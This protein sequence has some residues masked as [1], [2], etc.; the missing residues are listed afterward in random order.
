M[1]QKLY[2]CYDDSNYYVSSNEKKLASDNLETIGG[3]LTFFITVGVI[4]VVFALAFGNGL[5][6]YNKY[7]PGFIVLLIVD[8]AL[9]YIKKHYTLTFKKTRIVSFIFYAIIILTFSYVD[10]LIYPE[11]RAVFFPCAIM[12]ICSL[13]MDY[14]FIMVAYKI[15][16][17][18][19]F[20]LMDISFKSRPVLINDITVC[21]LAI[22]ASSFCH[23]AVV[24]ATLSRKEDNIALIHKSET[25]LLTGLLNKLSFEERCKEYIDK[26]MAGAKCT[27]FIMDLDNF[28]LVNDKHGHQ[29]G[30]EVLKTFADILQGYF[31]PDDLIGRIGGDEFMIFVL[32]DMADGFAERR[33]RSIL[34]EIKTTEICGV[35]GITCSI[36][37]VEDTQRTSFEELYK[38]AD[39]ALYEAKANG[40][41]QFHIIKDGGFAQSLI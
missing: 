36:G 34:H 12:L 15:V 19:A 2:D 40:K 35:K 24:R 6:P 37:I 25:D 1:I 22:I 3:M 23:I 29:V 13:Y 21:I 4:F 9:R 27:M 38:K 8:L 33:C 30:D 16:L 5:R 17:G 39:D 26:K 28:K 32:G 31:H 41:A 7:F 18:A 10:L 14:F 11:S 20:I